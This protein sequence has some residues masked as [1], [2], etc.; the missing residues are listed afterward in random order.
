MAED[1]VRFKDFSMSPEPVKF[2]LETDDFFAPP[3]LPIPVMQDLVK[4]IKMFKNMDTNDEEKFDQTTDAMGQLFQI[5]L[6][7]E[8]RERFM[9]RFNSRGRDAIGLVRTQNILMWLLEVYGLR[10][11]QGSSSSSDGEVDG[12]IGTGS[13]AGARVK[14]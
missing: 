5:I 3:V 1:E 13:L 14:V 2:T 6:L 4:T 7:S 12:E 10:P 11:T 9:E 8:S